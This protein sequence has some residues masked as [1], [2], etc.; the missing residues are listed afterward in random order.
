MPRTGRNQAIPIV[1]GQLRRDLPQEGYALSL[2]E[3]AYICTLTLSD[4]PAN[5]KRIYVSDKSSAFLF[6]TPGEGGKS[7]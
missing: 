4:L 7:G 6:I 3:G 1:G 2:T 5:S